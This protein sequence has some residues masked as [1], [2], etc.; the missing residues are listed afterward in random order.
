MNGKLARL[1]VI[2]EQFQTL[3]RD[4][5]DADAEGILPA[6]HQDLLVSKLVASEMALDKLKTLHVRNTA[7]TSSST[8]NVAHDFRRRLRWSFIDNKEAKRAMEELK[9]AETDLSTVIGILGVRL[10]CLNRTSI[11]SMNLAQQAYNDDMAKLVQEV[12]VL[13][14]AQVA[15]ASYTESQLNQTMSCIMQSQ[16]ESNTRLLV[17]MLLD[18]DPVLQGLSMQKLNMMTRGPKHHS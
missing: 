7:G 2:I 13:V 14:Q 11:S 4:L 15:T 17:T 10:S 12:K 1:R 16:T 5:S 9:G 3:C 6:V 8:S 18:I